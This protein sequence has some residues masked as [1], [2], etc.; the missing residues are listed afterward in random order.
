MAIGQS[1]QANLNTIKELQN[2]PDQLLKIVECVNRNEAET[3]I[4][5]TNLGGYNITTVDVKLPRMKEDKFYENSHIRFLIPRGLCFIFVNCVFVHSVQGHPK[6][7]NFGDFQ[8][9]NLPKIVQKVFRRK[10]NGE[11]GHYSGFT[12]NNIKYNVFGSK[13]VHFVARLDNMKEDLA[14]YL[15]PRYMFASKIA[16]LCQTK[17]AK[18]LPKMQE[19]CSKTGFTFDFEA[20]FGDSQHLVK[21]DS[22]TLFFFAITGV[23][24]SDSLTAINP[25]IADDIFRSF[26]LPT[27]TITQTGS[28]DDEIK[29]IENIVENDDN[30]EGAVVNCIDEKGNTVY[31]YKHKNFTYIFRRAVREQM[32]KRAS[33]RAILNRLSVLHIQHPNTQALTH[34]MLQFNAYF[35][36]LPENEQFSFF[37]QWVTHEE[38]FRKLSNQE[39]QQ[40]FDKYS[41]EVKK[42]GTM[43]VY[44]IVAMP[45]S[46]KSY[47][48]RAL[49]QLFTKYMKPNNIVHLEQDMFVQSHGLRGASEAYDNAIKKAIND[50]ETQVLILAKSNH[51]SQVRNKTYEILN[52]CLKEI[53]RVYITIENTD[54]SITQAEQ[55]QKSRDI[56]LERIMKRGN[57]HTSMV[58]LSQNDI[59]GILNNVFV[60]QWE[61]L[62][63]V[64]QQFPCVTLDISADKEHNLKSCIAQLYENGLIEKLEFTEDDLKKAHLSV[65]QDDARILDHNVKHPPKAAAP[66]ATKVL[67][68]QLTIQGE[69]NIPNIDLSN[70]VKKT[71]FHITIA[72]FG[73]KPTDTEF[74]CDIPYDVPIIGYAKD[75]SA[76]ALLCDMSNYPELMKHGGENKLY[77]VTYALADGVKPVYSGTLLE[78]AQNDNTLVIFAEPYIV[79]A[80]SKRIIG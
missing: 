2:V 72:Y 57:A 23:K 74:V 5:T 77:H 49:K 48:A 25:L 43:T 3:V 19:Y 45:G 12:H 40:I 63:D 67:L 38:K 6:F 26:N 75:N 35:R 21:Y 37:S 27:V 36:L 30:S 1:N 7:G 10:E 52:K 79:P 64:E 71:E 33:M 56:C 18:S 55:L 22:D 69:L 8:P 16:D 58:N 65:E 76:C 61:P 24:T 14:L 62:T 15:E 4:R 32:R 59:L 78:K 80:T 50:P 28:S 60:K 13:N 11:C 66:K 29:K 68:D 31:V 47:L 20:C 51:N 41:E 46:G 9:K 54:D 53:E 34:E 73:G 17:Y 70:L 39:K 42:N 44:M